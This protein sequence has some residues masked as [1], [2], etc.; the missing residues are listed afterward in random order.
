MV[1]DSDESS[2]MPSWLVVYI[3]GICMG[4]ADAVPGV[5]GGTIALIVGI[6]ERLITAVTAGYYTTPDTSYSLSP[7]STLPRKRT[8]CSSHNRYLVSRCTRCRDSFSDYY[9]HTYC[10]CRHHLISGNNVRILF[11][12]RILFW[13]YRRLCMGS[14]TTTHYR[15]AWSDCSGSRRVSCCVHC[16]RAGCHSTRSK[17][18]CDDTRRC[19]RSQCNDSARDFGITLTRY[20]WTVRVYDRDTLDVC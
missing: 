4:A 11:W 3:K 5:S 13:T 18:P 8:R 20:S 15:Y 7:S 9:N 17:P 19:S 1:N 12:I 2:L 16:L 6:Y 14:P 10:S